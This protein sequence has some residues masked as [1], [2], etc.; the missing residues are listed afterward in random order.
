MKKGSE[1]PGLS[2]EVIASKIY[3]IRG[4]KVML[5]Q[6]L[7]VLY[8]VG[9]GNLNKAVTRNIK[10]FPEDFLFRLTKDEY[11]ILQ[12]QNGISSWGGRRNFPFAFTEQGV[13]ML[14][15]VLNSDHAIM[16]NIQIIRVFTKMRQ[17]LESHKEIIRQ[18]ESL[19]MNDLEQDRN[20]MLIFECLKQLNQVKEEEADF[21]NRKRIGF[22]RQ[23][24]T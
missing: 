13:A 24:E 12:F 6:D 18:L 8:G 22:Q 7:G 9:T 20:I 5:D 11:E 23:S 17:I 2:E 4:Q 21:K 16:I 14:S 3:L 1:G 10:R 15:S 19:K